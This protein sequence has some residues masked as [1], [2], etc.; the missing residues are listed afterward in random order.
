MEERLLTHDA[1][2]ET[3]CLESTQYK[4]MGFS[5][6]LPDVKALDISST[7]ARSVSNGQ[8]CDERHAGKSESPFEA[9]CRRQR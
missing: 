7:R 3:V 5:S 2:D 4:V 6:S 8:A 1:D 9:S